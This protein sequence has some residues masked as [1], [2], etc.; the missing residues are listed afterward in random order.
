M[1][2]YAYKCSNCKTVFEEIRKVDEGYAPIDCPEC[3]AES[4]RMWHPKAPLPIFKVRGFYTTD[5]A[6]KNSNPRI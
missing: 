5:Y 1:P 3:G 6:G 2:L 4:I